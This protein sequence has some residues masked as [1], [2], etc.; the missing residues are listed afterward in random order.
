M[1]FAF[2]YIG[3]GLVIEKVDLHG[4]VVIHKGRYEYPLLWVQ[5]VHEVC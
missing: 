2:K 5:N 1:D 4:V 3:D